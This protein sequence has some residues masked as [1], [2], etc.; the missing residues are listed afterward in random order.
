MT[1]S[2][3]PTA[4]RPVAPSIAIYAA[5]V[6]GGGLVWYAA[7]FHPAAMPPFGPYEFSWPIWL[8]VTLS[9]FWYIRGLRRLDAAKWPALWRRIAFF[10]G[11]GLLYAVTQTQFEYLAQRMFFTNRLQHVVMH[12]I[13][14]MLVALSWGGPVI[15][16]GGPDWLRR[17]AIS[18][19][20]RSVMAVVQ[21]PAIAAV[22]FVG[23]FY[24]WLIP[25][26][27]FRAMLDPVLYQVMNW[28]MVVDGILFWTLVL[29][30]RPKP[31]ARVQYGIRAALAIGVMFPQ[32]ALGA[33]I[34]FAERDLFPY[35]AFCGRYFQSISA[36]TDQQI[37]GL[38]I[39]IPPAMMS[40]IALLIVVGN[41]MRAEPR[42]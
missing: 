30:P 19:P 1:D 40:V 10:A 8:A 6:L 4:P 22:L 31:P 21:Q 9:V 37:G 27:H 14:A 25:P 17:I 42:D 41:M 32:I 15:L 16:A 2:A 34:T 23:L 35:Y 5:V 7:R 28:S 3:F 20:V 26:V 39:W 11:L 12:H 36:V 13:G 24:F 33:L 38:V 18:R 29:D